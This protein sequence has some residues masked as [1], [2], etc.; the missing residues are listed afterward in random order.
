MSFRKVIF[1]LHLLAGV[2][3]GVVIGVMSVTGLALA[4]EK[5]LIAW[6]ERDIRRVTL[7]TDAGTKSL[8]LDELLAKAGGKVPGTRPS[9]VTVE[10]DPAQ[11][12][13][14]SFGRTN[15]LYLNPYT[16]E[17]REQGA[18]RLRGFMQA[19]I[20]WHRYLAADGERRALGKAVTGACNAAFLVLAVSGLYLWWP[21]QWTKRALGAVTLFNFRLSGKARDFNWHN[22]IGLWSAPVLIVLTATAM[23]ISYRWAGNLIYTLTG[24][25][26]PAQ[27]AGPGAVAGPAVE[28]PTPPPGARPLG[29]GALIEAA[30]KNVPNWQQVTVRVGGGAPRGGPPREGAGREAP[31]DGER[32]G[33]S[34]QPVTVS[35]KERNGW[36]LFASLQ[37]TLN[38]YTGEVLRRQTFANENAGMKVRRWTRFLHTGE[39]LGLIGQGVAGLASLG[40]AFLVW[41]GFALAW[42]RLAGRKAGPADAPSKANSQ[43]A[44]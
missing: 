23:P 26:A 41:T 37:L 3:A 17:V 10:A 43:V 20:A 18:K 29:L 35:V 4:Y 16:G 44:V 34:A 1:W 31:R 12:V 19:M 38:P 24:T 27:G 39:A 36:P 11:A 42:R 2:I 15:S 22:V 13:L 32:R 9:A 6:A 14:V 33:D 30:Q 40:G 7:P 25:T 21:R 28:V 8:P 5:Q